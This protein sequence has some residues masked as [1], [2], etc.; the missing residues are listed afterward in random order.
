M[1][2]SKL[3]TAK[4]EEIANGETDASDE[5]CERAQEILDRRGDQL[6]EDAGIGF[7]V[8]AH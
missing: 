3:S 5:V 2:L 8:Y 7:M 4:L 6:V 1:N